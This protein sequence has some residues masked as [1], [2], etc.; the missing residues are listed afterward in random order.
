MDLKFSNNK[1]LELTGVDLDKIVS[2]EKLREEQILSG[3]NDHEEIEVISEVFLDKIPRIF[4]TIEDWPN[5]TNLLCW[6]CDMKFE[7]SPRF[8][9][10]SITIV[11]EGNLEMVVLGNFCS[12]S[13]AEL[14]IE[15]YSGLPKTETERLKQNLC[16]LYFIFYGKHISSIK[17]S[18][19][20]TDMIQYGGSLSP[21]EYR[22]I[23]T[24]IEPI[25]EMTK[26][27]KKI[28]SAIL[29]LKSNITSI[30]KKP[31]HIISDVINN[32]LCDFLLG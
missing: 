15:R 3:V 2:I 1:V 31:K 4:S 17:S 18:K 9:P 32:E 21:E 23:I 22:K 29:K 19:P 10:S 24:D 30:R 11:D 28:E 20:K 25:A 6:S 26:D 27:T 5:F 16:L 7:N 14:Y 8:I 12:F 13:C